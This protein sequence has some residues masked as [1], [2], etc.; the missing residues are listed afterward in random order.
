M[1]STV[2]LV[3]GILGIP[4]WTGL[5]ERF[6]T[7]TMVA[8]IL[9]V[10][11]A[12]HLLNLVCLDAFCSWFIK[13]SLTLSLGIGGLVLDL[14]GFEVTRV[15]QPPEVLRRMVLIYLSLPVVIWGTAFALV[16]L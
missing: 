6:D 8:S 14:S 7:P 13:A 1:A 2:T 11:S 5:S 12:G 15:E 16:L 3:S 9:V 4:L 10:G